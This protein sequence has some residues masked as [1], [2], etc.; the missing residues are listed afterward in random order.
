MK[1]IPTIYERDKSGERISKRLGKP[2]T[3]TPN[4]DA[5]WVFEGE[6]VATLKWDGTPVYYDEEAR[7]HK[8]AGTSWTPVTDGPEDKWIR[9]A[10]LNGI[11]DISREGYK[12]P[13]GSYEA[14]GPKING[15]P[16][17]FYHHT[18]RKHGDI[19]I[20][21]VPTDIEGLQSFFTNDWPN[22]EGVVWHHPDGR[23]AKIKAKDFGLKR[24]PYFPEVID[25]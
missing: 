21:N 8:R 11:E 12:L 23:M 2:L 5:L 25:G 1:K 19:V 3:D 7:W 4:E 13:Y 10:I 22:I 6:G 24:V 20:P 17:N 14:V 9:E 18:L 15:N 16:D